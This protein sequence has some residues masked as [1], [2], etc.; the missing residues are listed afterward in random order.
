MNIK[1]HPCFSARCQ[2]QT[3]RIHL[4]VAPRCNIFCR[5]CARGITKGAAL[6]GNAQRILSPREAAAAVETALLLCPDIKVAGVAGPGDPLAGSESL[7]ALSL[8]R[9]RHPEI[10]ACLSTNGLELFASMEGLMAA[11]VQTVTVTVNAVDPAILAR[12]NRGVLVGG[13]FIGGTEGASILIAAQERGVREAARNSMT[14][15]ANMVLAPGINS[16]HA[17]EVARA[18]RAWGADIM[19][20]IPLIPAHDFSRVPAPT[21]EEYAAASD[22][23]ARHIPVKTNCRRCRA[24]ACGIPGLSDFS[25]AVYGASGPQETFSHG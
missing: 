20:I 5:F 1:D 12:L 17:G 11:G 13:R 6:P 18:V 22:A 21:P 23:A 16:G 15:K 3:G 8:V 24:D 14:V 4:P 19:N 7:E 10:I 9:E 2:P 25:E